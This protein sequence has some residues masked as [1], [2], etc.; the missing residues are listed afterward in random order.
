MIEAIILTAQ[1]ATQD[2]FISRI[3]LIP[4][5]IPIHFNTCA[6]PYMSIVCHE[7]EQSIKSNAQGISTG[8]TKAMFS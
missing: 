2:V 1:T 3:P 8:F 4:T 7:Y 6:I 5:D